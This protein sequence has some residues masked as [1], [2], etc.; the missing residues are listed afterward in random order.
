VFSER[1]MSGG[2]FEISD[3]EVWD[4]GGEGHLK[5]RLTGLHL[6]PGCQPNARSAQTGVADKLMGRS[7]AHDPTA[8]AAERPMLRQTHGSLRP[9]PQPHGQ[10]RCPCTRN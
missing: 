6:K 7:A 8:L 9:I 2:G 3:S 5:P 1:Q 4:A 10:L